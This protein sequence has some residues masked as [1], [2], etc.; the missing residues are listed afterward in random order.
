MAQNTPK[1][2]V[3]CLLVDS[4]GH[5]IAYL[6]L[7]LKTIFVIKM[8]ICLFIGKFFIETLKYSFIAHKNNPYIDLCLKHTRKMLLKANR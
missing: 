8:Y 2:C 1:N 6:S 5:G 7:I 4:R 3:C